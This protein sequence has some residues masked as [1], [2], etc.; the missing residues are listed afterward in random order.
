MDWIISDHFMK[1]NGKNQS[2][3]GAAFRRFIAKRGKPD[4]ITSDNA[5]HLIA[6]NGTIPAPWQDDIEDRTV[7][8]ELVVNESNGHLSS[9]FL[10]GSDGST[11]TWLV[12]KMALS[13]SSRRTFL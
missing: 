2:R 8:V 5:S 6:A 9:N 10:H 12:K 7:T 3:R 11:N 13:K 1:S 4:Q